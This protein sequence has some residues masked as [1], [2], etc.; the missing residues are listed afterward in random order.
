M[1][2]QKLFINIS[3][4]ITIMPCHIIP[5]FSESLPLICVTYIPIKRDKKQIGILQN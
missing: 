4:H 1:P 5:F 2:T 3:L